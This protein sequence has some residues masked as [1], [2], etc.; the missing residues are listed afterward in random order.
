VRRTRQHV[1]LSGGGYPA[2]VKE[3]EKERP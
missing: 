2:K 1:H 3:T